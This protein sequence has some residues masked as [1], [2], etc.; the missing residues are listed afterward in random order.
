MRPATWLRRCSLLAALLAWPA[1]CSQPTGTFVKLDFSGTVSQDKPIASI[2]VDLQ[3]GALT[4]STTFLAP[5]QGNITLPSSAVLDI[6]AG[7]GSLVV[8]ARALA[9]DGTV[10]GIGNG[11]GTITRGKTSVIPVQFGSTFAD[12][13]ADGPAGT[14]APP[15]RVDA[16]IDTSN[17]L[18]A[19]LRIPTD[20]P[21]VVDGPDAVDVPIPSDRETDVGGAGADGAVDAPGSGGT[22]GTDGAAAGGTGGTNTGT[23]GTGGAGTG[24]TGVGGSDGGVYLLVVNPPSL[25]FGVILPGNSSPPQSF[26]IT[27]KGDVPTPVLSLSIS[28]PKTFP[29]YKNDCMGAVLNPGGVC[30][31]VFTFNPGAPGTVRADG[32]VAPTGGTGAKFQLSGTGAGGPATLTLSP[33]T[34]NLAAVDVNTTAPVNF[35]LTNG[36]DTEAGTITIQVPGAPTFQLTANGCG[37]SS[38]GPRS[39]CAFTVTFA[40]TTFGPASTTVNVQSSLGLS[41]SATISGTGRD[42]LP[43][44]IAFA[45][46]GSGTVT[47]AP[48]SCRSGATC[49]ISIARVDPN[50]IPQF[51]LAAQPSA[52]VLFGG[53]SG[54]CTGTGT[55]TVKMD[56][57]RSVTATFNPQMVTLNLTV[58]G[59]AGQKGSV[60]SDDGTIMCKDSCP[61]LSHAATTSFTLTANPVS[62]STFVGWAGSSCMGTSPSCTFPLTAPVTLTATFGPQAYMFVSSSLVIPGNLI[63]LEGADTEC[64]RLATNAHLPGKYAAWLSSS[65]VNA[66]ARVGGGGWLRT[67]GRP[68]ARDLKSLSDAAYMT[69]Y[70]PPRLDEYGKDLGNVRTLVATGSNA[71]G[72]G[73]G[74]YCNDYT[75]TGGS[76]A[77]GDA[78]SGAYAWS[79]SARDA[80]GCATD[81]HLYCFRSD[82]DP[83]SI[84]PPP[85][86]G[87]RIFVTTNPFVIRDGLSPDERCWKD[88]EGSGIPD[89]KTF[90]AFVATTSTP[91]LKLVK[92]IG[93]PWK[94]MDDVF[95]TQQPNDLGGGTLLAPIDVTADGKGYTN[96]RVWTGASNPAAFG[97]ATCGDW[98]GGA[99][100]ASGLVGDSQTSAAPPWFDL[101]SIPCDNTEARLYCIEP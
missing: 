39:Q 13:G 42:Y 62:G 94:R 52:L 100:T 63:G 26:T 5:S 53:W 60:V 35:T 47:G 24:G 38:L 32:G 75:D 3:F 51:V 44:T 81:R 33:S 37:G 31:V 55:C 97:S 46:T 76:L 59:L 74:A 1:G 77:M 69:V 82:L 22:G 18:A 98:K 78:A 80:A 95:V 48:Q 61:N 29:V 65:T 14:E 20:I 10:L 4:D 30:T 56:K 19:D 87:R 11:S 93:L 90:V 72:S 92:T 40:P 45:G 16:T 43:L 15:E 68:F 49:N 27:N 50:A 58:L 34:V 83:V 17:D 91:A 96:A 36:G 84:T 73:A 6:G 79:N 9:G 67:D 85:Q 54:D 86:S 66:N 2:A 99:T 41:A 7:A 64:A 23:G 28:D 71:D 89:P 12:A 57:A 101:M 88:A 21:T 25:D 70:Y 8:S